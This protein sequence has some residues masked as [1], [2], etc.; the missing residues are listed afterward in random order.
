MEVWRSNKGVVVGTRIE[1]REVERR[2]RVNEGVAVNG[3]N[4]GEEEE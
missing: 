3:I 4:K 2:R 1:K